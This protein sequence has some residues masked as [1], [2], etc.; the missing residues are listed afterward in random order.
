MEF[1]ETF[2]YI[3]K[4]KKGKENVVVDAL[5]RRHVLLTTLDSK[6]LGFAYIKDLY[7]QDMDF[8]HICPL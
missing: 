2:P 1:I 4:C 8:G 5:S 6:V 7:D 3:I